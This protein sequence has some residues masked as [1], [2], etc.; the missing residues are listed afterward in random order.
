MQVNPKTQMLKSMMDTLKLFFTISVCLICVFANAQ[1]II[2]PLLKL[3]L[4]DSNNIW[5]SVFFGVLGFGIY[6]LESTKEKY[7]MI[8]KGVVVTLFFLNVNHLTPVEF[9]AFLLLFIR[10]MVIVFAIK[11]KASL[12]LSAFKPKKGIAAPKGVANAFYSSAAWRKLRFEVLNDEGKICSICKRTGVVTEDGREIQWHADHILP[13]SKYPE[14]ALIRKNIRILCM[15]CNM[16]KGASL[17]E[18]EVNEFIK[19]IS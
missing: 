9:T 1:M 11:S 10:F 18:V 2:I 3:G 7:H 5:F 8:M 6:A 16:G 14:F 15:D 12:S 19:R 4:Q 13:R 17:S